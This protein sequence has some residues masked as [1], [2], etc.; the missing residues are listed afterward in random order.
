[1]GLTIFSVA[2]RSP[3]QLFTHNNR[4]CDPIGW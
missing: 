1:M 4:I 3:R 2:N